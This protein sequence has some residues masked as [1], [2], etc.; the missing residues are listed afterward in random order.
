MPFL[1]NFRVS[2]NV[3]SMLFSEARFYRTE[4]NSNIEILIPEG[5]DVNPGTVWFSPNVFLPINAFNYTAPIDEVIFNNGRDMRFLTDAI[6]IHNLHIQYKL[7]RHDNTNYD[8]SRS[9]RCVPVMEDGNAVYAHSFYSMTQPD[10]GTH[11]NIIIQK[12]I[13]HN[14]NDLVRIKFNISQ[15]NH[16]SGKSDTKLVI[17]SITWL[18]F[19]MKNT[20]VLPPP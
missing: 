20:L 16:N 10:S 15:D 2:K 5:G 7:I 19:S 13:Y 6:F 14:Y 11:D 9:L 18:V 3:A 1:Y 17:F 4:L 12:S 8:N